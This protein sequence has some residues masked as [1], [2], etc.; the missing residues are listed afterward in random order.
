MRAGRGAQH[1]A[2]WAGWV[3]EICHGGGGAAEWGP[4]QPT[5]DFALDTI[6]TGRGQELE[7]LLDHDVDRKGVGSLRST[8]PIFRRR[9]DGAQRGGTE[10]I[11]VCRW[12]LGRILTLAEFRRCRSRVGRHGP[13]MGGA[14]R[15][16]TR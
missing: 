3:A 1:L 8:P 9:G 11:I 12:L 4:S 15:E 7:A 2:D 5:E 6:M 13:M 14:M 10:N 16:A